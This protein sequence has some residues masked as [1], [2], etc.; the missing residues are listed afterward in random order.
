MKRTLL[1][2]AVL[3]MSG[4]AS[5]APSLS[6]NDVV[7]ASINS[8]GNTYFGAVDGVFY[9]GT[10]YAGV[11]PT[12]TLISLGS[13]FADTPGKVTYTYLGSEA[14]F[15]NLF[16]APASAASP[17]FVNHGVTTVGTS[18]TQTVNAPG[19]LDFKFVGAAPAQ[20]VNGELPGQGNPMSIGL[21]A[22]NYTVTSGLAQ[23]QSFAYVIGYNDSAANLADWDDMVIGVNIA[24]IPEPET[25]AMLLA[26]LGLMG[27]V[28]RRR[29]KSASV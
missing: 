2:V 24:P 5:A 28:A 25:Y 11:T 8:N 9:A 10:V 6:W 29:K 1:A 14:G 23:G 16:F 4:V 13:L 7:D 3:A 17:E 20:F 12:P 18:Y 19:L 27:F 21:I 26:G 15:S 22:K